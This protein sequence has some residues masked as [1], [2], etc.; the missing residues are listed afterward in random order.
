M[1]QRGPVKVGY[2]LP[3]RENIMEGRHEA[4]PFLDQAKRAVDLGFDSVWVGDSLTARPRHDPLTL[5]AGVAAAVPGV[6]LGTAVLLPALRNPVVLAQQLATIDQL[7]EGRLIVGVG[8]AGDNVSLRREFTAAG[9]PFDGRVGRLLE[10]VRLCRALWRGESVDWDGRWRV[11]DAT[12]APVP[13][14]SPGREDGPPIWLAAGVTAGV[15]RAAKHFDG[16]FPI[17]P[18]ADSFGELNQQYLTA[19]AAS[20]R[21]ATSAIYLTVAVNEDGDHGMDRIDGYLERYYGVPG[22]AMRQRQA[23]HAGPLDSVIE[24][25]NGFIAGGAD[26]VVLRLVGDHEATLAA[27]SNRR[28]D[29]TG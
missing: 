8:I 25:I 18:S 17:G 3:T 15:E 26:H 11:E 12:L 6:E 1:A 20:G 27:I 5:L 28:P 13:Y 10:G 14:R 4:R 21:S 2:L 22:P 9:V 19:A 7:S 29:I 23:C 24:F 16:W